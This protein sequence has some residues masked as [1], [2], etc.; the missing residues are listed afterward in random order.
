V[1]VYKACG[2]KS[3]GGSGPACS[4]ASHARPLLWPYIRLDPY[5]M[6]RDQLDPEAQEALD[7][8]VRSLDA[9]LQDLVLRPGDFV[10]IDNY[11]TVHGRRPFKAR[12]DGHDRWLKRINITKDLRKSRDARLA[13]AERLI[14]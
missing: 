13:S 9:A 5:F 14:Y 12:Y 1:V 10:F 4:S 7:A 6:D 8:I 2:S 11:R 3:P